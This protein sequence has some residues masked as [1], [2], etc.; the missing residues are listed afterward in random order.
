MKVART[1]VIA[2]RNEI[3]GLAGLRLALK[4]GRNQLETS[5]LYIKYINSAFNPN[6]TCRRAEE[7]APNNRCSS[8]STPTEIP[9]LEYL[10][11]H[12]TCLNAERSHGLSPRV[13]SHRHV[14]RPA[15]SPSDGEPGEKPCK[16]HG[17][18]SEF[19]ERTP[20]NCRNRLA[21]N[22]ALQMNPQA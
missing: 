8:S 14:R 5:L 6:R 22:V 3:L 13:A 4:H 20:P 1:I 12:A 2:F 18:K 21:S 19:C 9:L 17:A 7:F 16:H 11:R 15:F 10:F